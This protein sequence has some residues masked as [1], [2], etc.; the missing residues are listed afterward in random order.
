M[1][2]L[3]S[4]TNVFINYATTEATALRWAAVGL[5]T[6]V[7]GVGAALTQGRRQRAQAR[8][9]DKPAVQVRID[10]A[11]KI[12]DLK[13]YSDEVALQPGYIAQLIQTAHGTIEAVQEEGAPGD[14]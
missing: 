5:L 3:A 7:S 12:I 2:I 14:E 10:R 1:A 9:L 11:K 8:A 4:A 6:L 13:I